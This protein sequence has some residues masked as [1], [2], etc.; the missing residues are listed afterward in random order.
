MD[1]KQLGTIAVVLF[2]I[3]G[4]VYTVLP[5]K[6]NNNNSKKTQTVQQV[7]E[8]P[9]SK[10]LDTQKKSRLEQMVTTIANAYS[11]SAKEYPEGTAK[12]WDEV[13]NNVP[14]TEDFIDPYTRTYYTFS[15]KDPDYGQIQYRPNATCKDNKFAA[16]DYRSIAVR[17]RLVRGI[18]C[19]NIKPQNNLNL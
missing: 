19:V 7:K 8:T 1:K 13:V 11:A 4:V 3:L 12:G 15:Q 9:T 18:V 16:G 5:K 17:A 10:K 6:S 14:L 2:I